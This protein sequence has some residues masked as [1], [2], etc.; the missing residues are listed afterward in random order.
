MRLDRLVL[1][2]SLGMLVTAT[3]VYMLT[4]P[5]ALHR[6]VTP[7]P[8]GSARADGATI[9]RAP[10]QDDVAELRREVERLRAILDA[11]RPPDAL[12]DASPTLDA[13][14][15][16]SALVTSTAPPVNLP[17]QPLCAK[18][19]P[20]EMFAY[21][22]SQVPRLRQLP[23]EQVEMMRRGSVECACIPGPSAA[24]HCE[25]WCAAKGFFRSRCSGKCECF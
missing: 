25:D 9:D 1:A 14:T 11:A 13:N 24:A 23:P 17:Q 8:E 21:I 7:G 10:K 12:P 15:D 19:M 20:E 3:T 4:P 18:S 22:L 5:P 16:A 6:S 2:A